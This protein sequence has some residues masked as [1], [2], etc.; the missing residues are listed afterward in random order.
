MTGADES[1][2]Q[3]RGVPRGLVVGSEIVVRVGIVAVGILAVIWVLLEL[4]VVTVPLFVALLA[5][6]VLQVPRRALQRRGWPPLVAT[7]V[8]LLGAVAVVAGA[9]AAL[10][11]AFLAQ[12]D[13]LGQRVDEG[14]AEIEE[15]LETGPLGIEDP[16]LRAALDGAVDRVLDSGPGVLVD[17]V[18]IAAEVL[19]GALLAVVMTFFFV[20]DGPRITE[21]V[22]E[23]L[24]ARRRD[25]ARRAG[26]AAW[27]ALSAYVRGTVVVGVV[28][29]TVIG[30]GLALLGVPLAL[31]LAVITAVSAFFPLI[32]AVVAGGLAALV[33]L[34]TGSVVEALIVVALTVVVQQ[35]EGDVLSPVVMGKALQ[36]H[37]LVILVALTIGAVTAGI[38]GA[39]LAVPLTGVAV[40]TA[41]AL[42]GD[43]S[44]RAAETGGT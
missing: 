42:R 12:T 19:A 34:V 26:V 23:Q 3:G 32:G 11:P 8:V 35:I 44:K 17:G 15:W 41:G 7:W 38:L 10:V 28:N 40:A 6:T 36:L 18:T 4:R 29:G 5:T 16:D 43:S 1:A 13:E 9:V 22:T 30:I 39:F 31:P 37:P 20:K 27:G 2:E 33:A 21:W 24:P 25:D 14:I